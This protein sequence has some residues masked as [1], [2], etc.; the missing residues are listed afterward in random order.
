MKIQSAM[1][2]L[3]GGRRWVFSLVISFNLNNTFLRLSSFNTWENQS[4]RFN[5]V[6]LSNFTQLIKWDSQGYTFNLRLYCQLFQDFA[7][8]C[9]ASV[10]DA[11]SPLLS[12]VTLTTLFA[13]S[14]RLLWLPPTSLHYFFFRSINHFLNIRYFLNFAYC[15]WSSARWWA[16][17]S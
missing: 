9:M 13:R 17:G 4:F 6:N 1:W 3:G 16:L 5:S 7:N 8:T 11:H 14:N 2:E 10:F 15:L 12:E